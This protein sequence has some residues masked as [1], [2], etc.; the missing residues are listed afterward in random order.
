MRKIDRNDQKWRKQKCTYDAA[1]TVGIDATFVL[2]LFMVG[3]A[4]LVL[5]EVIFTLA[6]SFTDMAAYCSFAFA[7]FFGIFRVFV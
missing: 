1:V 4:A 2:M 3:A 6:V 7:G 5:C